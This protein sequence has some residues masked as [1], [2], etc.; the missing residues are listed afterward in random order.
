MKCDDCKQTKTSK[1]LTKTV[2]NERLCDDCYSIFEEESIF[3]QTY[4]SRME[5]FVCGV[6]IN[7]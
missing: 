1:Q 6:S 7:D 2:Y 4:R 5:S 3:S